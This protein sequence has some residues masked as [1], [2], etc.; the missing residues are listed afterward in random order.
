MYDDE[1]YEMIMLCTRTQ[2]GDKL[3][4]PKVLFLCQVY[5]ITY[6]RSFYETTRNKWRV[7][8]VES[9]RTNENVIFKKVSPSVSNM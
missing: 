8:R 7:D 3:Y 1:C 6:G 9:V 4:D 2:D 5:S